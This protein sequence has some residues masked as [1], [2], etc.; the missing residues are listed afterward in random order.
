MAIEINWDNAPE[1]TTHAFAPDYWRKV[2]VDTVYSWSKVLKDWKPRRE[3]PEEW[4]AEQVGMEAYHAVERPKPVENP[5]PFGLEWFEHA[6]HWNPD[7]GGLPFTNGEHY[8]KGRWIEWGGD[9]FNYWANLPTTIKRLP[10]GVK[11]Q[12]VKQGPKPKKP[13]G[14]WT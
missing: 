11:A 4:I 5:L 9:A 3:P 2:T 1:G 12:V 8:W 13:V 7:Y 6:T 14:W 10:E